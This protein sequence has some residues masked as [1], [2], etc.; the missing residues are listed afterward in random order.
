MPVSFNTLAWEP[1][2]ENLGGLIGD[3]IFLPSHE[4]DITGL[5]CTDGITIAGN[6]AL[7]NSQPAIKIYAT[8]DSIDLTDT[9]EGDFD[10][11]RTRLQLQFF[12]P[13]SKKE[14]A[15]LKRKVTVVPGIW[16]VKD[17]ELN[18]RLMGLTI[19]QKP[20]G[21]YAV[22][23]E[24]QAKVTAKEGTQGKRADGRRG[25]LYTVQQVAAHEAPFYSGTIPLTAV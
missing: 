9:Q 3:V 13:G 4:A 7:E 1:G 10:G 5:T 11:E 20:D 17:T 24:I 25:T 12:S 2:N 15:I 22:S 14:Q 6:L 16:L 18:W 23:K 21:T 8:E 19:L